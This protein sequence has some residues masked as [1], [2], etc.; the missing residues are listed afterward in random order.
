MLISRMICQV[1]LTFIVIFQSFKY[2]H[3][4]TLRMI[5]SFK[6][7]LPVNAALKSINICE[8]KNTTYNSTI[9]TLYF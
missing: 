7:Y 8:T 2:A 5:I 9:N 1:A 4:S 6:V 3:F